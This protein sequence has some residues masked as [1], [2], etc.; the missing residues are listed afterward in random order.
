LKILRSEQKKGDVL[1]QTVKLA[2]SRPNFLGGN[3]G[4]VGKGS[5]ALSIEEKHQLA[6]TSCLLGV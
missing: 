1:V 2:F 3:A 6:T 5:R 4:L